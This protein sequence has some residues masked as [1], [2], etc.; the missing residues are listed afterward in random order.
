MRRPLDVL[1]LTP[2]FPPAIG[3]IQ[4]LM[5]RVVR[6]AP[7]LT[8]RVV[9]LHSPGDCDFDRGAQLQISRIG[10]GRLPRMA[11]VMALNTRGMFAALRR[12]PDV[13]ISGHIAT[14]PAASALRRVLRVPVVQYLY[15]HEVGVRPRLA[16]YAVRHSD[17]I[18][19]ISGYTRELA[20]AAGADSDMIDLIPPGVDLGGGA[21]ARAAREYDGN[22]RP[23]TVLTVG[24]LEDRYKG[25]D[26]LVRALPLIR[27]QYGDVRWVVVGDGSLRP[28]LE[29]LAEAAGVRDA[30][31]FAGRVS[32]AERDSWL[33]RAD[34]FAMPSRLPAD[35]LAGEGFGI[36]FLEAGARGVPVVAGA[37][38]GALDA[39]VHGETGLLVDPDDHVAVADAIAS[40]LA[41]PERARRLGDAGIEHAERH[42][43]TRAA[44]R[45]ET[46][47]RA[48]ASSAPTVARRR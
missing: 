22:G 33:A 47:L 25:H 7:G 31:H 30:V 36:V 27:A 26:V 46:V 42:S 1:V 48:V 16:R 34:V 2:D 21:P 19:A 41:D 28:S 10:G 43:W 9:T 39:V 14:S 44:E 17:R 4:L 24:R 20:L 37:A 13:I 5:E 29:S 18:V 45:L 40:L 8:P 3:G 32:D 35:G 15:G 12:R 6:P 11:S 23:R 38:G